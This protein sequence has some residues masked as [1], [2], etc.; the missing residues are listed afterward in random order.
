MSERSFLGLDLFTKLN[1]LSTAL[2]IMTAAGVAGFL[3]R[4]HAREGYNKLVNQGKTTLTLL[5]EVG[6]YAIY[7]AN[8]EAAAKILDGFKGDADIAYAEILDAQRRPIALRSFNAQVIPSMPIYPDQS[9]NDSIRLTEI[10]IGGRRYLDLLM[11]VWPD[12]K[13]PFASGSSKSAIPIGYIR[14]GM[15][16][17]RQEALFYAYLKNTLWVAGILI[18][19]S[20]IVTLVITRRL[21]G[22]VRQLTSAAKLVG[23]GNLDVQVPINASD[24]LAALTR[25]FNEMT[26]RLAA[27]Q[28]EVKQYQHRLEENQHTLEEKVVQRTRELETA[29][30]KAYKLAQHDTLTGLP[31]RALLN[32]RLKQILADAQRMKQQVAVLFIDFDFF[33]RINDTFGHDIGDQLL[34]GIAQRL[35]KAVRESDTVARF[36]GDEFLVVLPSLEAGRTTHEVLNLLTRLQQVLAQPFAAGDQEIVLT[37][38]VGVSIFPDDGL[39]AFTLIKLADTAMYAAKEEGRNTCRFFTAEMNARVHARLKLENE[40]RQGLA[41][42]E[43]YL[44]YQ[45]Q[46]DI[47]TGWPVG[48]EALVRWR[49]PERGS[50]NP[51]EFIPIAEES[52]IIHSLGMWV[53]HTACSQLREW[54]AQDLSIR[55]SVNLSAQQI[56]KDNWLNLVE[57]ALHESGLPP[58]YL[59]LEITESVI[60][61]NPDKAVATLMQLKKMGVT[62]TVDD[63]G[64]GY[65]SLNYLARLPLHSVKIDQRFVRGLDHDHNDEAIVHAIIALSH[66][67]GLRVIAEGVETPLQFKF[68]QE[69]GCEEAQGYYVSQPLEAA[70]VVSWYHERIDVLAKLRLQPQPV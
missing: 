50:I 56:E 2:I 37:A 70:A 54:L 29:T 33:K 68:L 39:D 66:S 22:P 38:S 51:T 19:T 35:N 57:Q 21:V 17:D 23:E 11:T 64:T 61:S 60:I 18:I 48:V 67:L 25:A 8:Q 28:A 12:Q 62:I 47:S 31:N 69:R 3:L 5:S 26:V 46:I 59:D 63:F 43:F 6:E 30:A 40:M 41:R 7:T 24:E 45:P 20:I 4:E 1:L 15:R 16:F 34:I 52:G 27:S 44:V 42:G 53:L 49:H 14:L 55:L 65:S 32:I 36:G 9:E 13:S 10:P 58:R